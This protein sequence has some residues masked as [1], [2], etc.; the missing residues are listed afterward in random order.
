MAEIQPGPADIAIPTARLDQFL[1]ETRSPTPFV[2]LDLNIAGARYAA[3]RE[4][5]PAAETYYAV[6]ANPATEVVAEL[7]GLGA[8]FDLSSL[9]EI[10]IC[11]SLNIPPER[12]SFG[13]TVKRESAITQASA[14]GIMAA[15]LL[16]I[17]RRL[18]L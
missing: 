18:G 14:D 13:N 8:G 2:V 4:L 12:L 6:K 15:D 1:A 11:M 10:A 5:L 16:V 17:A 7:A 9:G 3:L